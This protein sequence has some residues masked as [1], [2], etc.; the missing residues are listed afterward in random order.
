MKYVISISALALTFLGMQVNADWTCTYS[1]GSKGQEPKF[2][3]GRSQYE[4]CREA[5]GQICTEY[6]GGYPQYYQG[7]NLV[8]R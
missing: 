8:R 5:Q 6:V 4:A 7:C 1:C 3:H 2:G